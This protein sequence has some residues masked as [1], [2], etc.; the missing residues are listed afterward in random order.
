MTVLA[1][2]LNDSRWSRF[3]SKISFIGN[4][5]YSSYLLHFPLQL[6]F[7]AVVL[8]SGINPRAL[9]SPWTFCLFFALL[10][11]LS[12]AS[13]YKFERPMQDTLRSKLISNRT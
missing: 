8:F 10:I 13:Y 3:T 2:A 6:I 7:L 9:V 4:M 11:P 5:S 1:L 12:L